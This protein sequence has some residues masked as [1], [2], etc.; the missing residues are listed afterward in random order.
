M[1]YKIMKYC[2][3][4]LVTSMLLVGCGLCGN[5]LLTETASPD[6]KYVAAVFE[7]NC[8]ATTPFVTV[9]SLRS[10]NS[11]FDPEREKDWVF[12]AH[13]LSGVEVIWKSN[14]ELHILY[15]LTDETT[16]RTKWR[17]VKITYK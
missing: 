16:H 14:V 15:S 11:S 12:T 6:R 8:G 10:L 2:M 13:H 1:G 17:D 7:R 9:V 3:L 4:F 5:E